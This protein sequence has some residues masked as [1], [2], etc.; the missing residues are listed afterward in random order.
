MATH[1]VHFFLMQKA[2]NDSE[3]G[4]S[5]SYYTAV[6]VNMA[7][8]NEVGFIYKPDIIQYSSST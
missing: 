1:A 4:P 8:Q 5:S 7:I 3:G 6:E 2:S